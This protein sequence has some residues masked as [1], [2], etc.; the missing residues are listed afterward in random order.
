MKSAPRHQYTQAEEAVEKENKA[1]EN[2][3]KKKSITV[4]ENGSWCAQDK[5]N[6]KKNNPCR[7]RKH[8]MTT[9]KSIYK[10]IMTRERN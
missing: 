4:K 8:I 9:Y 7:K 10:K 5:I 1:S 3:E 2:N 6:N